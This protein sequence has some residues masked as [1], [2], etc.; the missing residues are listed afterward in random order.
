[1]ALEAVREEEYS[2]I[3]SILAES[4]GKDEDNLVIKGLRRAKE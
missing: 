4:E 1:M 3:G 2:L